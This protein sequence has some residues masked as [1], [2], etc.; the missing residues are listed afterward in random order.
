MVELNDQLVREVVEQVLEQVR[1]GWGGRVPP[2]PGASAPGP[3]N[4]AAAGGG[5][6]AGAVYRFGQFADLY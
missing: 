2:T 5:G 3:I 1:S 6:G 4:P